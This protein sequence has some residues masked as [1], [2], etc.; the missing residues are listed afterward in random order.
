MVNIKKYLTLCLLL[1]FSLAILAGCGKE[2]QSNSHQGAYLVI[3]DD[4]GR[5][6]V[7]E[8]KPERIIPLSPSYLGP[9]EALDVKIVARVANKTGVPAMYKD[10]PEVGN[11]YNVSVEKVIAE[12]PD[13]VILYKGMNDKLVEIFQQNNIPAVVLEMR[14]YDQVKHTMDILGQITGKEDKAK[15]LND[16]MDKQI[17]AIASKYPNPGVKVAILHSTAQQVT[18]QLD[19]SIA[20]DVAKLLHLQ[21]IASGL[22]PLK[23]NNTAAPYSLETIVEANPDTILITSMGKKEVIKQSMEKYV[24]S[25]PAWQSLPAVRAGKVEY[26]PQ[27]LF[28]LSPGLN[29]PKAVETMAK[30]VYKQ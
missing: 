2:E 21:N 28:L 10:L 8:H 26:L 16:E 7:L 20:G 15:A 1:L 9:L 6:V 24:E 23:D 29:Y 3:T 14:T 27:D 22:T 5:Q 13:L 11:V 18:V 30:A 4:N 12:K 19:N 25:S 17:A